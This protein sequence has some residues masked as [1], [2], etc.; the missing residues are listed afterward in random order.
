MAMTLLEAAK[1]A[2]DENRVFIEEYAR[3]T[4]ILQALQFR[5][6][7]GNAYSYNKEHTLPGV[8]FRGFNEGFDESVGIVNPQSEAMKMGGGDLDVDLAIL[9]TNGDSV[10]EVH[11]LM[12][13]KALALSW[14]R[15]FIKGD[16]SK[17]PRVFDGLQVRVTGTQLIDNAPAG[18][19]LSLNKLD[20]VI[21]AVTNPTHLV[22]NKAIRR[23]LSAAS[24]NTSV[25][26][27]ITFE[28]DAF[29]RKMAYYQDL[30]IL[31]AWQDNNDLEILPF[32]EASGDSTSLDNGSIYCVSIGDMMLEGLNFKNSEGGYGISVR[33]L[34][35]LNTKPVMRTRIDWHTSIA[36]QHGRSVARLRGVKNLPVTV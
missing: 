20:E 8:G 35:E 24:R 10:R 3:T 9:A 32:D 34:G 17:N 15:N 13:L 12:K 25:G 31:V 11:E 26:G 28:P 1:L 33:D 27:Y 30:P 29:G 14:T 16:S 5:N 36:V 22:V 21:D 6:V 18:A 7:D 23:R 4:D 19:A 2:S